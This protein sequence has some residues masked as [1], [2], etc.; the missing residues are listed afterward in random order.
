VKT[1]LVCLSFLCVYASLSFAGFLSSPLAGYTPYTAPVTAILD[2]DTTSTGSIVTFRGERGSATN[3]C[4]AYVGG[5]NVACD[6][7]NITAPRAYMR[8][9]GMVWGVGSINYVDAAPGVNMYMWYDNHRGYDYAVSK[10]T[11]VLAA[12]AGAVV[13]WDPTWGQLTIDHGNG[14]RTIYTH[15]KLNAPLPSKLARGQHIGWVS[16]IAPTP[17]STHLHF[18]VQMQ[19]TDGVWVIA[20]PYGGKD[21]GTTQPVLWK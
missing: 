2:H 14:Y 9:G 21:N 20:D 19:R 5:I 6:G 8:S 16:N 17:V 15:M 11:L 1:R 13:K 7:K 10:S 12:A 18:V 4:L 3:G